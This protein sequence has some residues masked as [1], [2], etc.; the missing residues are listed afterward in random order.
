MPNLNG[1]QQLDVEEASRQL[2]A[3]VLPDEDWDDNEHLEK[4]PIRFAKML[5]ELTHPE[6]FDF[7]VFS[8]K[9]DV[10]E[11]VVVRDIPFYSF[12]AHHI[13]PFFGKAHVA[14][15]P[16]ALMCGLSK[17]PRLVQ[18]TAKGLW[19]QEL[20]TDMIALRMEEELHPKGLAVVMEA[21]HLCMTMRGVQVPGSKTTT[22]SMQGV[23]LD[24]GKHARHEFLSLIQSR[25]V[26]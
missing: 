18:Y 16:D 1:K 4:T 8:N 6:E 19:V 25:G 9:L 5:H 12:C 13:L 20:L 7:T 24:P 10:N 23:F 11:M 2:L 14:Y 3:L 17:I 26:S 15:I 21:E 22:S